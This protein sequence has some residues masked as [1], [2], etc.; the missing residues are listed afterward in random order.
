LPAWQR[1]ALHESHDLAAGDLPYFEMLPGSR[2]LRTS[3]GEL[4][5]GVFPESSFDAAQRRLAQWDEDEVRA[6]RG[7][8][9][10]LSARFS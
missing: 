5:E 1:A 10:S 4:L 2:D 3:A 6:S 8:P 9:A 7:L